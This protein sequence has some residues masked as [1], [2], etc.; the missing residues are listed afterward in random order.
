MTRH[1][2]APSVGRVKDAPLKSFIRLSP[3]VRPIVHIYGVCKE[4]Y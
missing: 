2:I 1:N 4:L 3:I